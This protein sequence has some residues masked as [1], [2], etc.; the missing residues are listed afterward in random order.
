M[1]Y[2]IES[3]VQIPEPRRSGKK[4]GAF[5]EAIAALKVG[6]SVVVDKNDAHIYN[7]ARLEG[8]RVCIRRTSTNVARVW[9]VA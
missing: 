3:G 9:R 8:M 4:R 2:K 7:A 5:R 6:E 1:Q